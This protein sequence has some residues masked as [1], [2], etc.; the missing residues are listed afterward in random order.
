MPPVRNSNFARL[1][2]AA[3]NEVATSAHRSE[4]P[5][6]G[7]DPNGVTRTRR[8]PEGT[9]STSKYV[10]HGRVL[11]PRPNVTRVLGYDM[12]EVP[13]RPDDSVRERLSA[14]LNEVAIRKINC[15][16]Y[17][18]YAGVRQ[19]EIDRVDARAAGNPERLALEMPV[20]PLCGQ[21]ANRLID[22]VVHGKPAESDRCGCKK[23][24]D[25]RAQRVYARSPKVDLWRLRTRCGTS[26]ASFVTRSEH[27]SSHPVL[28]ARINSA[29][30][31]SVNAGLNWR[32]GSN[33]SS[34]S[35]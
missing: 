9:H 2:S 24:K 21:L 19:L 12:V 17:C 35:K 15:V 4:S 14:P 16:I 25:T 31:G 30:S 18:W 7:F 8:C 5:S 34:V 26:I 10:F 33:T 3:T 32:T 27:R 20:D 6:A 22:R 29:R 11:A 23:C 13:H 28:S 1:Q